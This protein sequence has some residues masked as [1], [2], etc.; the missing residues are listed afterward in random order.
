MVCYPN[1][2]A[3][4]DPTELGALMNVLVTGGAGYIG[5]HMVKLLNQN[6]YLVTTLDDLSTGYRDAVLSGDFILGSLLD[7]DLLKAVFQKKKFDV[8]IHFAGSIAVGESV[9]NPSKYYRNNLIASINLLEAMNIANVKKL[10]FSSTAAIFGDPQYVPIDENHPK[11]P[12]NPY[13]QTKLMFEQVL[14]N[15]D[16]ACGFKSVSLRYFNASGADPLGKLGERHNP[17]THLIPLTLRATNLHSSGLTIFGV[18]YDTQDG[19]CVRDYIHVVDLCEAHLL[20]IGH[21]VS[22]GETRQYNLGNGRGYSVLEIIQAVE[23]VTGK[24]VK[25]NYGQR[26]LGDPAVLVADSTNIKSDWKWQPKYTLEEIVR[27]AWQW[28][29]NA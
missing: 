15:Y 5:S 16:E 24:K 21:L 3:G 12:I 4:F 25:V 28:E 6:G 18:D 29:C 27:H 11:S 2:H 14:K 1:K 17:E 20:A 19:T 10:V 23:S 26:R 22:N 9:T 8:V 13:G 7:S